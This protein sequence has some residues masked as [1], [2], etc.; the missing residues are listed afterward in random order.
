MNFKLGKRMEH[1]DIFVL[2]PF[3]NFKVHIGL[4]ILKIWL[5]FGHG[6]YPSGDLDLLTFELVCNVTPGTDNLP[7]NSGV[8]IV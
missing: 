2:H 5:I 7:A 1:E 6:I 3:I 8:L 4:P